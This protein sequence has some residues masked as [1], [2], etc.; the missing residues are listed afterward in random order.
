MKRQIFDEEVRKQKAKL[1]KLLSY[2]CRT[3]TE[4][5]KEHD[6]KIHSL[7]KY[8]VNCGEETEIKIKSL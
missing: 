1:L 4:V 6:F 5:H 8:C 7:R 3:S 2:K